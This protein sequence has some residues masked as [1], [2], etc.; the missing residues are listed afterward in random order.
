MMDKSS[1]ILSWLVLS[2][3]L[4][5][6]AFLGR[7]SRGIPVGEHTPPSND[8]LPPARLHEINRMGG[9]SAGVEPESDSPARLRDSIAAAVRDHLTR[10]E[11]SRADI[12]DGELR[13]LP[14]NNDA[15][16]A[17]EALRPYWLDP[18]LDARVMVGSQFLG[19]IDSLRAVSVRTVDGI[20][21]QFSASEPHWVVQ[22]LL[23]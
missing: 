2:F 20:R 13:G 12:T 16:R 22:V 17:L 8:S 7:T 10:L 23:R 6:A 19:P 3:G 21:L 5:V 14:Q 18:I 9:G 11:E 15:Y 1:R 4:V